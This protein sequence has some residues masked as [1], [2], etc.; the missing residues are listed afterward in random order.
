MAFA[1]APGCSLKIELVA[2]LSQALWLC[3]HLGPESIASRG[4]APKILCPQFLV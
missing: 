3:E 4:L 2:E 1:I